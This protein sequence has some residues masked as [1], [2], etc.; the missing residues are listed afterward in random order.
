[1]R[2]PARPVVQA[3]SVVNEVDKVVH[4]VFEQV[5]A[6]HEQALK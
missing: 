5:P 4:T 3:A 2:H 6:A 1:M